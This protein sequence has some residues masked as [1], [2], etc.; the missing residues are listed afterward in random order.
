MMTECFLRKT[1]KEAGC[2][3]MSHPASFLEEYNLIVVKKQKKDL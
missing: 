2:D 3:N 1:K